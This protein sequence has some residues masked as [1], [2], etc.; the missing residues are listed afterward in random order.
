MKILIVACI[1]LVNESLCLPA[2]IS[3][4]SGCTGC[5]IHNILEIIQQRTYICYLSMASRKFLCFVDIHCIRNVIEQEMTVDHLY[6][7]KQPKLHSNVSLSI[8][9]HSRPPANNNACKQKA[10]PVLDLLLATQ[11]RVL[12]Y[13]FYVD[14][15]QL[16]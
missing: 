2:F 7:Y 12:H 4:S 13:S 8:R 11:S 6:E 9:I 15:Q 14:W 10:G 3:S 1:V 16:S 5:I